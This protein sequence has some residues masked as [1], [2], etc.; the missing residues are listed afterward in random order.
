MQPADVYDLVRAAL[1]TLFVLSA[2]LLIT[3]LVVGVGIALVQALTGVQ[4]M[5]LTFVPKLFVMG[6]ALLVCMPMMG[7]QMSSFM[8]QIVD[9]IIVGSE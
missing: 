5:T 4:E 6:I 3:G 1:W 9:R 8:E 2:P 7:A